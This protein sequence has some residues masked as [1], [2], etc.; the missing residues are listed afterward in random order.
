MFTIDPIILAS[1]DILYSSDEA[2]KR[3]SINIKDPFLIQLGVRDECN[4]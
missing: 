4:R 2:S 3:I 1:I